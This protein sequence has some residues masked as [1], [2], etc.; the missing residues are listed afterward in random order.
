MNNKKYILTNAPINA[1][2]NRRLYP[3][4]MA[5]DVKLFIP[6]IN[7]KPTLSKRW[8]VYCYF[9][10]P[11]TKKKNYKYQL[12]LGIN[13]LKTIK[14][15]K[16]Y[17]NE[18]KNE[19][20]YL[21]KKGYTPFDD[22]FKLNENKHINCIE[23]LNKAKEIKLRSWSKK[24]AE[25]ML[26]NF[27]KFIN[28]LQLHNFD[29]LEIRQLNQTHI[30]SFLNLLLTMGKSPKTYNNY[31]ATLSSIFAQLASD[32]LVSNNIVSF[33]KQLKTNPKKN[34]PFNKKE[35]IAIKNYLIK[36]DPYLYNYIL[37]IGYAFL[38]PIEVN[39]IKLN[40]IDVDA[41]TIRI[42]A[43]TG[44]QTIYLIDTLLNLIINL[45]TN[46][47][48]C[49][50]F[51]QYGTPAEWL[52]TEKSRQN[53]YMKRFKKVK[54]KF[55]LSNDYSLYSFRHT[56]IL[57][58]YGSFIKKGMTKLEAQHKLL[59]IT[60]HKSL[61][62]LNNYLRDIGALLPADYSSDFTIDF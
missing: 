31:R 16:Q 44:Y 27:D 55:D 60:R 10:D 38:R 35:L 14:D 47:T 61:S 21:I 51:G 6:K 54:T 45:D 25:S 58:L 28:W 24:T 62:G 43:K 57:D 34:T 1:P 33:T 42:K 22:S 7:G 26:S 12:Y 29:V 36:N 40:D 48:N 32:G 39:R 46:C 56:F 11:G 30:S 13:R 19:L 9:Y 23:A 50:L 2:T 18:I 4:H 49:Y 37:F 41:R 8:Y 59:P 3:F 5:S 20:I 53:S 52:A 17:G 15:R